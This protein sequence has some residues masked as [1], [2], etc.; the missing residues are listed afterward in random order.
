MGTKETGTLEAL[1]AL[2]AELID[3]LITR[4]SGRVVKTIVDGLLLEFLSVVSATQWA[5]EN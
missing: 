1:R 2:R 5:L 3:A 4:S